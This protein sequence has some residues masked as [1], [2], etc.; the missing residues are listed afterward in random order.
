[1]KEYTQ[2]EQALIEGVELA[3]DWYMPVPEEDLKKYFELTKDV[4]E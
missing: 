3:L 2:E 1:M 4:N